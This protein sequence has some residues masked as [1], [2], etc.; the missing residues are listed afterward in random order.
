MKKQTRERLEQLKTKILSAYYGSPAKDL[1]VICIIGNHGQT[2]VAHYVYEILKAANLKVEILAPEKD[3]KPSIL[4]K[5]L[6]D[7]WQLGAQY[8]VVAVPLEA[9]QK[10]VIH[11]L[12]IHLVAITDINSQEDLKII[13][14]ILDS[15]QDFLIL[16]HDSQY[17]N[18]FEKF[19]G[20][21]DT[22]T[23][24][25]NRL[26]LVKIDNSKLYKKGA[27]ANLII[28]TKNFTT[29]T[30]VSNE[31]AIPYMA[32]ATTCATALHITPDTII[33]G[34]SNYLPD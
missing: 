17:F 34:I 11:N 20:K 18:N 27:E 26:A 28:G 19:S 30:F 33:E 6:S 13:E 12:P 1:K 2:T 8:V 4:Q 16:N 32:C 23:Y 22:L 3:L 9:A 29:A 15:D 5:S 31:S 21:K 14:K 24:G 25:N 10:N 7:A